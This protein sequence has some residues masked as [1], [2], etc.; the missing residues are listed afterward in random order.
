MFGELSCY[1]RRDNH[2]GTM[3][4]FGEVFSGTSHNQIFDFRMS[5]LSDYNH[6]WIDPGNRIHYAFI[7]RGVHYYF[8]FWN[9]NG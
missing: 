6:L 1:K 9:W 5:F 2:Q 7:G 8:F 3:H 4:F